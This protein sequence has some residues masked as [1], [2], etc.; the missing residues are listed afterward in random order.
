MLAG[1]RH[2]TDA[3]GA[4]EALVLGSNTLVGEPE[5]RLTVSARDQARERGLPVLFDP[6][7]RPNRWRDMERA[8]ALCRELCDSVFLVK[9]THREAE[10]LTGESDPAAA[11]EALN[12]LG[13]RIAVVTLGA[14]GAV[15]RGGAAGQTAAP[16][17]E[18]V[19]T[20]GAG[21]AFMGALAAGLSR[22]GWSERDAAD[23]LEGAAAAG[24]QACTGWGA[25]T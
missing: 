23:A 17:V 3:L 9:T 1:G 6:N 20:L 2:L 14:E 13:A 7:L 24:A 10:L 5:R 22:L 19:S 15:M 21:D 12:R 8:V 11:A 16:R 4:S 25:W 18:V